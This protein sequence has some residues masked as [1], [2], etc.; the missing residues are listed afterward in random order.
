MTSA[1]SSTVTII[2]FFIALSHF[3]PERRPEGCGRQAG[4]N[5]RL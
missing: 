3:R 4:N 2:G 1:S 5:V